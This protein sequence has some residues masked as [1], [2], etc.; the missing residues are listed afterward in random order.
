VNPN[1]L[2]SIPGFRR[3]TEYQ[4]SDSAALPLR[5]DAALACA[6]LLGAGAFFKAAADAHRLVA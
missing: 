6:R 5:N 3:L 4:L 1:P 2:G